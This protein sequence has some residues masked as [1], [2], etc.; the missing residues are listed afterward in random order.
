MNEITAVRKAENAFEY[1]RTF[2]DQA[3]S[4]AAAIRA[5]LSAKEVSWEELSFTWEE[6]EA[7]LEAAQREIARR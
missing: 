4:R 3:E 6:L 7:E 5:L 1:L 2:P